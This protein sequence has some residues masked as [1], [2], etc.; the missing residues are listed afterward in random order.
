M[1]A[2]A[3]QN[4]NPNGKT[5]Y[6]VTVV[7]RV[8]DGVIPV[9]SA[10]DSTPLANDETVDGGGVWDSTARTI[11]WTITTLTPGDPA[12]SFNYYAKLDL[13][14]TLSGSALVNTATPTSWDSLASGGKTYTSTAGATASVTPA[15]PKVD[16]TKALLSPN[17]V[18][19]GDEVGFSFTLTNNGA[20]TAVS[21]SAVDTLPEGWTYVYGSAQLGGVALA[22]PDVADQLTWSNLGP[23]A[24]TAALTITYRAIAGS[25][26]LVGSGVA[27]TN[28]VWAAQVTDA[29]GGTSYDDGNG[30]Y[31]G[32][33]GTATARIDQADLQVTKTAGTFT[34]GGTGSFT[35]VVRNNGGDTAVGVALH[36]EL[37]LPTGVTVTTVNAGTDGTCTVTSGEVDCARASLNSGA[38]WTV[39]LNL[40]IA[41][42][43]VSGTEVPNTASVSARTADR[44]PGNHSSTATGT[45]VTSADLEVVKQV[46]SPATGAVV[47]GTSIEWARAKSKRGRRLN[48]DGRRLRRIES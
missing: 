20:A 30:S 13:A 5:A 38:T 40:A 14:E 26:V 33:S 29:T 36:D 2:A 1:S 4:S 42:D 46:V 11:T 3:A 15:F 31:I 23:L 39:T 24:P 6:N 48:L 41:A 19:I 9:V 44:T 37:K 32:T 8:P 43:V 34:A 17:P 35:M 21:L 18:Y 47:A 10:T 7:D 25:S 45:V 22:D 28:T 27:R 12:T 16:A